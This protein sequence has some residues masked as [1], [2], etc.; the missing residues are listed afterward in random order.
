MTTQ[1]DSAAVVLVYG[2][3]DVRRLLGCGRPAAYRLTKRLGRK[4]GKRYVVSRVAL[5]QWLATGAAPTRLA[6]GTRR[7]KAA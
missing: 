4:L 5:E 2:V 6:R 7:R 3:D 1:E